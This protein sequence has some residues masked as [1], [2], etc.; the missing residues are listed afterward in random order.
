MTNYEL[1][2]AVLIEATIIARI[3]LASSVSAFIEGPALRFIA[4]STS[5]Q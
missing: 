2:R 5:S 4:N 1:L 3:W